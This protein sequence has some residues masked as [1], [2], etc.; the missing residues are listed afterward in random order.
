MSVGR[1]IRI[2]RAIRGM[3]QVDLAAATGLD[4]SYIS[5]IET[6]RRTPS[7]D[8]KWQLA[9]A[10]DVSPLFLTTLGLPRDS[11]RDLSD[12]WKKAMGGEFFCAVLAQAERDFGGTTVGGPQG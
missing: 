3:S 9:K 6:D 1:A 10:F 5:L 4:A 2:C 11:L 12:D 7:L 8:V